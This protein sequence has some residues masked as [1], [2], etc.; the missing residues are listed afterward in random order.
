MD[1][2]DY[3]KS[4]RDNFKKRYFASGL[5]NFTHA[6]IIEFLLLYGMPNKNTTAEAQNIIRSCGSLSSAMDAP[7]DLLTEQNITENA[8]I[9]I[10]MIPHL[11]RIYLHSKYFSAI[12]NSN[13]YM[14]EDKVIASFI[15]AESEQVLLVLLDEKNKE[16]YFNF[17][18]RG[19]VNAS[20]V[21]IRKIIELAIKTKASTAYLAH[22]HPSGIAYPSNDD[23]NSTI[24][25]KNALS[26]IG[27]NLEN[28]FIVADS[29]CF[30]MADNEEFFDIFLK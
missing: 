1:D 28:H 6:E 5:K 15:G 4:R 25:L 19:S 12:N 16:V 14:L 29:Q 8:A 22:N 18:S 30:C 21:Y 9:L 17:I 27:V 23:I 2:K 7:I 10:K 13:K 11:S 20:E 3:Y 26:A 24:K